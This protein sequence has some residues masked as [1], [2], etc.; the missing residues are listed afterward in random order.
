MPEVTCAGRLREPSFGA[1][2]L[3]AICRRD[4][5]GLGFSPDFIGIDAPRVVLC[6]IRCQ[7]IAARLKGMIDPNKHERAALAAASRSGGDFVESL[8]KTDLTTFTELEWSELIAV[9]VTA[10]QESLRTGYA[11]DPPF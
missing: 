6:S 4:S 8:S 2:K 9:V 11:D 10:F 1:R 5:H 7:H 3:C